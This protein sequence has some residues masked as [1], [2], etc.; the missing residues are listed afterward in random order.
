MEDQKTSIF[1]KQSLDRVSSPEELDQYLMVTGPGVWITLIA[2][3]VL[4]IGVLSWMVLGRLDTTIDI[5]VVSDGTEV[6]CYVPKD[7]AD[8]VLKSGT[9]EVSEEEYALYDVGYSPMVI[10]ADTDVNLLLAGGLE[11][12]TVVQPLRIDAQIPDGTYT[13]KVVVETINPIKFIIN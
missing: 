9:I 6:T 8:A 1:R 11:V 12:G 2:I 5:A 13:G 3:I 4:L 10:T 7:K